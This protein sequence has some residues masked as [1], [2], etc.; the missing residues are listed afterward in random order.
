MTYVRATG[1][2]TSDM[3]TITCDTREKFYDEAN[4]PEY[5]LLDGKFNHWLVFCNEDGD[6]FGVR[7]AHEDDVLPVS[8]PHRPIGPTPLD[9]IELPWKITS[10]GEA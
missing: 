1:E 6:W 8:D 10:L 3:Q 4:Y 5:V 9:L 2:R 7:A